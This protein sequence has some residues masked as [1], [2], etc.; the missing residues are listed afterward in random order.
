MGEVVHRAVRTNDIE[1]RLAEQGQPGQPLVVLCHGFPELW[2]SWR[3]QLPALA[4][5]GFHVVAPDQRGYG[6]TS[7][8]RPVTDYDIEHLSGDL[9]GLL[10]VLDD[11]EAVFVGHDWGAIVAWDLALRAPDRVRGVVAMSVPFVPRPP[12]PPIALMETMAGDRFFYILYFQQ[13]GPA[14]AELGRNPRRALLDLYWSASGDALPGSV[15]RMPRE[16]TGFLDTMSR[17]PGLP[18]WLTPEDL[19]VFAGE[20]ART[21]FTGPLNW[22]RNLDRNWHLT[23]EQA[24]ARVGVPAL[25]IA[26][27]RDPVLRMIPTEPMDEFVPGLRGKLLIPGA[28]HW[29]QQERPTEVNVA[30][31]EFLTGLDQ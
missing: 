3:H 23:P 26:G 30:L 24:G 21:G 12:A 14:D 19:D 28:G 29:I 7:A 18:S 6:Q 27:M 15:K 10:D 4:D 31:L 5:A 9:I 17:A 8:P 25:F 11:D 16:G 13:V 2:Y 22:Y 1:M 20:F